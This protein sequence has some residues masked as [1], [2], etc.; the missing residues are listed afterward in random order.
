[1]PSFASIQKK[2]F[3]ADFIGDKELKRLFDT[4]PDQIQRRAMREG[5][6]KGAK[7]L[8]RNTKAELR[9]RTKRRTGNLGK[10]IIDENVSIPSQGI[11]AFQVTFS[12]R[13]GRKGHHAHL[14]EFG[15]KIVPRGP[16]QTNRSSPNRPARK[17]RKRKQ[18]PAALR[19]G[20]VRGR[21]FFRAAIGKFRAP[22][23]REMEKRFRATLI[24]EIQKANTR[25]KM[26]A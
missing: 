19:R 8:K 12:R 4:L 11:V 18:A 26:A 23:Q 7:E 15:H 24:K 14:V 3:S 16:D 17:R 10:S 9:K 22:M 13:Q 6:K 2:A 5:L 21:G 25:A 20:A 1:M